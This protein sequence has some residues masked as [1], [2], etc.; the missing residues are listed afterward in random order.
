MRASF[1]LVLLVACTGSPPPAHDRDARYARIARA[2]VPGFAGAWLHECTWVIGLT[3][4]TRRAAAERY[5]EAEL[6]DRPTGF[7]QP[8]P[9]D[10]APFRIQPVRYD[11]AQLHAWHLELSARSGREPD[12]VYSAIHESSNRI[13]LVVSAQ[14]AAERLRAALESAHVPADAWSVEVA[15]AGS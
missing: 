10:S 13:V 9:A 14:Q 6:R 5:Y 1:L 4:P 15:E 12:L 3:D 8:C 2:D 11:F 7:R